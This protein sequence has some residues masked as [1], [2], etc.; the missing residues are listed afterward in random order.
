ATRQLPL[1]DVN[2]RTYRRMGGKEKV[3]KFHVR[4]YTNGSAVSFRVSMKPCR[5]TLF[6]PTYVAVPA[7]YQA[8]PC[9]RSYVLLHLFHLLHFNF[10]PETHNRLIL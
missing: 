8:T 3:F 10:T 1:L 6:Y 5:H 4:P 9:L 2:A 7:S